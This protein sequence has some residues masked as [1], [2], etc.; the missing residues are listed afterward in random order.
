MERT[1]YVAGDALQDLNLPNNKNGYRI[2]KVGTTG[3]KV[4]D[5]KYDVWLGNLISKPDEKYIFHERVGASDEL[6]AQKEAVIRRRKQENRKKRYKLERRKKIIKLAASL[7]AVTI[8]GTNLLGGV[9]IGKK[10]KDSKSTVEAQMP[11]VATKVNSLTSAD[12]LISQEYLDY[13]LAKASECSKNSSYPQ[14]QEL[15][16]RLYEYYAM[17]AYAAY[18][19]YLDYQEIG[20]DQEHINASLEQYQNELVTYQNAITDFYGSSYS[21]GASPLATAIIQDGTIYV[22][23]T[24]ANYQD[25]EIPNDVVIVNGS[26]YIPFNHGE[27]LEQNDIS[28]GV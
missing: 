24:I 7:A 4:Y 10:S 25:N 19:D 20:M 2:M 17:P 21:F 27:G 8:A 15:Y 13:S 12:V 28:K 1:L 14:I 18:Y 22:P 23:D 5:G 26:F 11:E 6:L 3:F 16:N 9:E